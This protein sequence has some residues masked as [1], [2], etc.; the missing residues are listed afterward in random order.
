MSLRKQLLPGAKYFPLT[1]SISASQKHSGDLQTQ[2][3]LLTSA[4]EMEKRAQE[5]GFHAV[6]T[7]DVEYV[8]VPGYSAPEPR[9]LSSASL[10]QL[11]ALSIPPEYNESLFE[12]LDKKIAFSSRGQ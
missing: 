9:I 4:S 7:V 6:E 2:L 3:A 12:W 8:V 10:P 1:A 5:L 11:S